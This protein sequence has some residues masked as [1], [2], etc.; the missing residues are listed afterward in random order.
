[1]WKEE[2]RP[3]W[4]ERWP[5]SLAPRKVD[6]HLVSAMLN[7]TTEEK[8]EGGA[9]D[10]G[11]WESRGR[12]SEEEAGEEA[13]GKTGGDPEQKVSVVADEMISRSVWTHPPTWASSTARA[14]PSP[15]GTSGRRGWTKKRE[16]EVPPVDGTAQSAAVMEAQSGP[17]S[18]ALLEAPQRPPDTLSVA[19]P[20]PACWAS[21][22]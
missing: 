8:I 12:L 22:A 19:E 16:G 11:V 14:R 10:Q 5:A 4:H 13:E 15:R 1:M 9:A 3:A 7:E 2:G 6:D 18:R 20:C 17:L 21:S